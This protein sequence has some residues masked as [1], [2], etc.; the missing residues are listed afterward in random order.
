MFILAVAPTVTIVTMI[1]LGFIFRKDEIFNIAR[2]LQN[3][4]AFEPPLPI[5]SPV[6]R[7]ELPE[8]LGALDRDRV[9]AAIE[10]LSEYA[11]S[12][13][14]DWIVGV[15]PGGR[16][17]SVY[18]ANRI[19]FPRDRCLF[20]RTSANRSRSIVF[21]PQRSQLNYPIAGKLL[22]IDD[23]S[24][25]GQTLLTLKRFF[26]SQNYREPEADNPEFK[27]KIVRFAIM[28][29]VTQPEKTGW[30]FRPDHVCYRTKEHYFRLPWSTLSSEIEMAFASRRQKMDFD[31]NVIAAYEN[32]AKDYDYAL[33][34]AQRF[35]EDDTI[36]GRG[37]AALM[38]RKIG[39]LQK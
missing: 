29:I 31:G 34:V 24:R 32:I 5:A 13:K 1:V 10:E 28:L 12:V 37:M 4:R 36:T 20:V 6:P 9:M 17:L 3:K 21:E 23:I 26:I 39:A 18:I 35:M 15:H 7:P 38:Q 22:A 27:L 19:K 16:L 14:P 25:T 8:E 33:E 2:A 30:N 11:K